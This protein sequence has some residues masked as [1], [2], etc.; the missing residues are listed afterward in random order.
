[1]DKHEL[2]SALSQA[3]RLSQTISLR[4]EGQLCP[5]GIPQGNQ[6]TEF[7]SILE[8][9]SFGER[10]NINRALS[11]LKH[12]VAGS[13]TRQ[14]ASSL[15]QNTGDQQRAVPGLQA[16]KAGTELTDL[17]QHLVGEGRE[18]GRREGE[19]E[20][21]RERRREEGTDS[22]TQISMCHGA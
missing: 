11:T 14:K 19:R 10:V 6:G 2:S 3:L 4:V 18:P 1:V 9:G 12:P 13:A 8:P 17:A 22:E 7:S 20:R 21:K 16:L 5:H 15:L